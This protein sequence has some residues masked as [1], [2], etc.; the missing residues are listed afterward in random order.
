MLKFSKLCEVKSP[1]RGTPGS[2]GIDFFVPTKFND[3][4]PF[5]LHPGKDILIPTG[6][7][8]NIPS[9]FAL[10]GFNKSG[11]S[12]K[13]KLRVGANLVDEDYAGEIHIHLFNDNEFSVE[14]NPDEKILQFVL[15]PI[16]YA[17]IQE[18]PIDELFVDKYTER[19]AGWMGSTNK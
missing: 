7:K 9:G 19:G 6:I 18:V 14:I 15:I 12:I 1:N 8:A 4:K 3:G 10:I 16:N 11:I 2:A 17:K 5:L 13:K